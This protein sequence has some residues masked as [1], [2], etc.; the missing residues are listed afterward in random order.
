MNVL[1]LVPAAK[2][3]DAEQSAWV[4]G[5][6]A[7][8]EEARK[9]R[10][11]GGADQIRDELAAAGIV[12]EDTPVST[13]SLESLL[14]NRSAQ[15]SPLAGFSTVPATVPQGVPPTVATEVSAPS[16]GSTSGKPVETVQPLT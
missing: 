3:V 16:T 8:R 13:R 10:D 5:R 7:A 15:G 9:S 4:E 12:L 1:R 2:D 14:T 11:F 6:I